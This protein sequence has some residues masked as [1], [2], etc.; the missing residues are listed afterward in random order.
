MA[1]LTERQQSILSVLV[2]E[3]IDRAVPIG[4]EFLAEHFNFGVSSA[5]IRNE[6]QALTDLGYLEQPYT[7]AGRVPANNGYKFYVSAVI[8]HAGEKKEAKQL[9]KQQFFKRIKASKTKRKFP[10]NFSRILAEFS[11]NLV[12]SF[13]ESEDEI[14]FEGLEKTIKQPE[15]YGR[16]AIL[17]LFDAIEQ[18][19]GGIESIARELRE[20]K[21]P[22]YIGNEVPLLDSND[23]SLIPSVFYE[24]SFG[25]VITGIF[26]PKRMR[27][28]RNIELMQWIEEFFGRESRISN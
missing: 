9:K 8:A 23:Y 13:Y 20:T 26:G 1:E 3:Y 21:S 18:L 5:T 28:D 2:P 15:F 17:N 4:S 25:K 27:Y 6:L 14:V 16:E 7:S 24:D 11:D 19:E 22:V 12:W 10:R